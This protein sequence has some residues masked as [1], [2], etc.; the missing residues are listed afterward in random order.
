MD[1]DLRKLLPMGV[2]MLGIWAAGVGFGYVDSLGL[3]PL[4]VA[5]FSVAV[6]SFL[7]SLRAGADMRTA[8]TASFV[9]SYFSIFAALATSETNREQFNSVVGQELWDNFT[10]LVGVIVLFYFGASS[11]I[12]ITKHIKNPPG[13]DMSPGSTPPGSTAP[14][15]PTTTGDAPTDTPTDTPAGG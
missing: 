2:A 9:I 1:L 7:G 15:A 3:G 8:I 5:M 4:S 11:A 13:T 10:Y 12:E 6:I 14:P